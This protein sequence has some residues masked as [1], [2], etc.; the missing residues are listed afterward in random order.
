[1]FFELYCYYTTSYTHSLNMRPLD[2]YAVGTILCTFCCAKMYS[3]QNL[4][5]RKKQKA[6]PCQQFAEQFAY[7]LLNIF[8]QQKCKQKSIFASNKFLHQAKIIHN[9]D[10]APLVMD[11][12]KQNVRHHGLCQ[13]CCK[14][15][16]LHSHHG[17]CFLF[18]KN[19]TFSEIKCDNSDL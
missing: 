11:F 18:Y 15:A 3:V 16:F 10:K 5:K 1:M 19:I 7:I 13:L 4:S 8:A 2:D 14:N 6:N 17:F 9:C 12:A